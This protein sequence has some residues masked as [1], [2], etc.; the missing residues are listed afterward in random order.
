MIAA[1]R[2]ARE[3]LYLTFTNW[4]PAQNAATLSLRAM[5]WELERH[6]Q[7]T[8]AFWNTIA[9][10]AASSWRVDCGTFGFPTTGTP[11]VLHKSSTAPIKPLDRLL[12]TS[13]LSSISPDELFLSHVL[14]TSRGTPAATLST[15]LPILEGVL[16]A[17][18]QKWAG[19]HDQILV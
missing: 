15:R 2:R 10:L 18:G 8:T 7:P 11:V 16:S 4:S 5:P 17:G 3:R 13:R 19:R 12:V 9:Q 1:C 6:G 14:S